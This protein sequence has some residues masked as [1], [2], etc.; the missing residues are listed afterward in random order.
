VFDRLNFS[1]HN[2]ELD[3]KL[4]KNGTTLLAIFLLL[5]GLLYLAPGFPYGNYIAGALGIATG[6]LILLGK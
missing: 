3:M 2:Q 4:T 1:F 5:S 6:L